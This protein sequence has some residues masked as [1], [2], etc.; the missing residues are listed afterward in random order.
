MAAMLCKKIFLQS[1][2]F[3]THVCQH[4]HACVWIAQP[5]RQEELYLALIAFRCHD[6]NMPGCVFYLPLRDIAPRLA[7]CHLVQ[8]CLHLSDS[9]CDDKWHS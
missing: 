8:Q 7:L 6:F 5:R 2:M 1:R 9:Q 3:S 4:R